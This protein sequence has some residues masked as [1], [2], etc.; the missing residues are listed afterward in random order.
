MERG[1]YEINR[2][3][4]SFPLKVTPHKLVQEGTSKVPRHWHRSLEII[5]VVNG[6]IDL[7][8]NGETKSLKDGDIEIIH[9]GIPHE[10]QYVGEQAGCSMLIAYDHLK[11]IY[12][13]IDNIRFVPE[14]SHPAYQQLTQ[15]LDTAL[16]IYFN[17]DPFY[18]LRLRS[19]M[20]EL[21]HTLLTYFRVEKEQ[22]P[23]IFSA[24][25]AERYKK[26]ISYINEH[27]H[28]NVTLERIAQ[29][30]GYSEEH[31]SRSFKKY[32]NV[33]FKEYLTRIR[34]Y[35]ARKLVLETDLTMTDIANE[36]G[37]G[38]AKSFIRDFK[39]IYEVTPLQYRFNSKDC[40]IYFDYNR[41]H[42][43]F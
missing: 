25:Y 33:G 21:L 32:M 38:D 9:G 5:Y 10:Y 37:F 19:V 23:E 43:T 42:Y 22:V 34:L 30:F 12:P 7:W 29:Q 27:Y 13:E 28:E 14:P 4:E 18:N 2:M 15:A 8:V 40:K 16:H 20:Y 41:T 35:Y 17:R 6:S 3:S 39:Q 26:V 1:V 31:F 36:C 11:E 24:K